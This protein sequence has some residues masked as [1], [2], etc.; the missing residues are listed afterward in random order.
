MKSIDFAIKKTALDLGLPEDKVKIVVMAYWKDIYGKILRGE[1]TTLTVRH[2]GSFTVSRW[3]LYN[4]IRKIIE[5]I[6]R[7]RRSEKVLPEK[8]EE[9][10]GI[11]YKRLRLCLYHRN[12]IAKSYAEQFG[13]I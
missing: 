7:I 3:K 8:K 1:E 2:I 11:E 12:I 9:L 6:R 13:N 5:K 10:L 4:Y